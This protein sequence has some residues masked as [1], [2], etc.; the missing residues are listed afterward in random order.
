MSTSLLLALLET[1]EPD[2]ADLTADYYHW[3]GATWDGEAWT[4]GQ[5][6]RK[7]LVMRTLYDTLSSYTNSARSRGYTNPRLATQQPPQGKLGTV[8]ART[9]TGNNE[10]L[11]EHARTL[12]REMRDT[13]RASLAELFR[14]IP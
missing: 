14:N 11:E 2:E 6:D 10:G 9:L 3:I 5:E 4:N 12:R 1:I 8:L 13:L 7:E